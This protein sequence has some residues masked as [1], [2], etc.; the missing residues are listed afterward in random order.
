MR[1]ECIEA[2]GRALGRSLTQAEAQNIENRILSSMRKLATEDLDAWRKLSPAERLEAGAQRAAQDVAADAALKR[3]RVALTA[4]RHDAVRNYLNG[5]SRSP[6]E[7][8]ERLLAFYADGKSGTISVESAA[9]AIKNES[10]G[11]MLDVFDATRGAVLGLFTNQAGVVDLV[12]ELR[13]QASGNADAARAAKSFRDV[14]EGLRQRFNRAGGDIGRLEDWGMP[15]SHSQRLVAMAGKERW[16]D[17]VLG[18]ADRSR[19][20]NEDGSLMDDGQMR[21]FLEAAYDTISTNGANKLEPGRPSGMGMRANRGSMERQVHFK[22]AEAYLEYQRRYSDTEVLQTLIGHVSQMARDVALVEAL[23]PNPNQMFRYWADYAKQQMAARVPETLGKLDARIA[24][25]ETIYSEVSGSKQPPA[26]AALAEGF[27]TYRALNVA[28]RLGSAVI[29]ALTDVGT[30]ALTAIHNGLPVIQVMSNELRALNPASAADRRI[31]LRAGLGVQQFIGA[32]NRWGMDGLA[33][34][35]QVS[36][37][38]ARYAQGAAAGVMKLSGMNALTGAGQQAF[39]S[40]LMDSLGEV[41]RKASDLAALAAGRG[42]DARLGRRL[43]D[44]GITD[45]DFSVWKLAQP[46]D[47]RGLGDTV[48]TAESIYRLQDAELAALSQST[49]LSPTTLREQAATRLMAYVEGESS[50]AVIEPGVRERSFTTANFRRGTWFG[51]LAR[52]AL[53]FK[54]FPIAAFMRHGGRAMAQ[55]G[56]IGKGAYIAGLVGLTTVMGGIAMQLGEVASGRDPKDMTDGRFWGQA[57]LKGGALGLYG[58]FLFSDHTAYGGSVGS[59]VGGPIAG[60]IETLMRATVGNVQRTLD[61]KPTDSGAAAVQLL[62][63]KVPFANLWY[64]KAATD[65]LIFNQL[66]ELASPGYLRRMEER[67]RKLYDQSY[68]WRP[69]EA[70][71]G[72]GPALSRSMGQ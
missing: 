43:R 24:R 38:I 64:T 59:L 48:L 28:S 62:K 23:G 33:Q 12:R 10:L 13:G 25:L 61:G 71:P 17:D 31:A 56:A 6:V 60:D 50:M 51:E 19:Y 68:Y 46:E 2:V 9:A 44:A 26:S 58:D 4:L 63:G 52:S 27:D 5:S 66:Q 34:D 70:A 18:F 20:V 41:T 39:G 40:V 47:W 8:L 22:D 30:S 49:G 72:R 7:A 29:T 54:A 15:Q 1:T 35:A 11:Q 55:D 37:R 69:G 42:G 32:V 65:R 21:A 16:V 36:S 3:R 53:Q 45:T 57:V 67:G 14:A